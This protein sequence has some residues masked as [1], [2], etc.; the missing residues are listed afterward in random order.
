MFCSS[1]FVNKLRL[2]FIQKPLPTGGRGF[3][4]FCICSDRTVIFTEGKTTSHVLETTHLA[5][6]VRAPVSQNI[7]GGI[8][9]TASAAPVYSF[10]NPNITLHHITLHYTNSISS[11]LL[12]FPNSNSVTLCTSVGPQW[13]KVECKE[14][15]RER[16]NTLE[17]QW[18]LFIPTPPVD[19]CHSAQGVCFRKVSE[20]SV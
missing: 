15:F 7:V 10:P 6:C 18:P 1:N 19:I 5:L 8:T 11:S 13:R 2:M 20:I 9:Q 16:E 3:W 12:T 17:R 14:N 4:F